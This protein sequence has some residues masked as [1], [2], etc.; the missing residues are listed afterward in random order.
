MGDPRVASPILRRPARFGLA[1]SDR[2][3]AGC[4]LRRTL[5]LSN[6]VN[7]GN[8]LPSKCAR[9]SLYAIIARGMV[10]AGKERQDGEYL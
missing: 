3:Y 4:E 1:A 6:S 8:A 7:R 9:G 5:L 10:P 2:G